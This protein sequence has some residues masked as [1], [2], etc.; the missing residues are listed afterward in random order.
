MDVVKAV[1]KGNLQ[2][3]IPIFKKKKDLISITQPFT[4][5]HWERKKKTKPKAS[6][7]KEIIQIRAGKKKKIENRS[8]IERVNKTQSWLPEKINKIDKSLPELS[9]QNKEKNQIT[10]IR[11]ER[12]NITK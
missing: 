5:R 11:N 6:K 8:P 2:L 10:K 1:F 4:L 9:K 12:R 7:R 3:E